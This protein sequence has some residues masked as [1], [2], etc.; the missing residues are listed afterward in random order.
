[1]ERSRAVLKVENMHKKLDQMHHQSAQRTP[2]RREEA[3][4]LHNHKIGV[5]K[6]NVYTSDYVLVQKVNNICKKLS[7]R[8]ND[9]HQVMKCH[10]NVL[11]DVK[12]FFQVR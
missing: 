7:L 12:T 11:I 2:A 10:K 6:P 1:M 8:S 3:V 4:Q 5:Q 9:P